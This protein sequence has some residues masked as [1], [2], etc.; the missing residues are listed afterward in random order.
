MGSAREKPQVPPVREKGKQ[1]YT[2][3]VSGFSVHRG[4]G[5]HPM[6]MGDDL[7]SKIICVDTLHQSF[8][9]SLGGTQ[10]VS[11]YRMAIA[12]ACG[13][14]SVADVGRRGSLELLVEEN[15]LLRLWNG[16]L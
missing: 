12:M 3:Q 9:F 7:L 1:V 8:W 2:V 6:G 5:L 14:W 4:L 10:W 15:L 16:N 13:T 11:G